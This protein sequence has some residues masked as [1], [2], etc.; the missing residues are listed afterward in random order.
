MLFRDMKLNQENTKRKWF[1]KHVQVFGEGCM[2]GESGM[3]N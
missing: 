1:T 2:L 3:G